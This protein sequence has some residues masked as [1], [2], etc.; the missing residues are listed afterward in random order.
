VLQSVCVMRVVVSRYK[1]HAE[2]ERPDIGVESQFE[3]RLRVG[4][5]RSSFER[6]KGKPDIQIAAGSGPQQRHGRFGAKTARICHRM[7]QWRMSVSNTL[8]IRDKA[9]LDRRLVGIHRVRVEPTLSLKSSLCRAKSSAQRI[10]SG[11]RNFL[12]S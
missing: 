9:G 12:G 11:A 2:R 5:G 8:V 6:L 4:G 1:C 7:A 10:N 3:F